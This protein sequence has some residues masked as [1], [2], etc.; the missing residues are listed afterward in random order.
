VNREILS[1][2]KRLTAGLAVAAAFVFVL[3]VAPA[4]AH[5][6]HLH[7]AASITTQNHGGHL[8]DAS[9]DHAVEV[10]V[11]EADGGNGAQGAGPS[12]DCCVFCANCAVAALPSLNALAEPFVLLRNTL[13]ADPRSGDGVVPDGLRRPPRP[14]AIT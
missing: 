14:I 12:P 10:S 5:P 3:G 8:A 11:T 1:L 13:A 4:A 2:I 7:G 6:G 9:G